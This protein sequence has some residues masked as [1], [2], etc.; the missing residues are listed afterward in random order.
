MKSKRHTF[1]KLKLA[2]KIYPKIL[3]Y[4]FLQKPTPVS[5]VL[6]ITNQCNLKCDYCFANP[7]KRIGKELSTEQLLNYIDQ[8]IGLG[9]E[10]IELQGGE[11]TLRSDLGRL[12]A[13]IVDRRVECSIVTNGFQV[14]RYLKQL[15]KCYFV[16]VSIDGLPET[17]NFHRGERAYE[18]AVGALEMM[19]DAGI[20]VRMHGVITFTTTKSDIDHLINLAEKY[21]TD[22][23]FVYALDTGIVKTGCGP[24]TN[25]P[26]QI[27]II[28]NYLLE[29]KDRGAP[30][31]SKAGAIRQALN[32]PF[33]SQDIL[34]EKEMTKRQGE[35]LKNLRIPRCLWGDLACFFNPDGKLYLC[36]RGFDRDG[37][38]VRIGSRPIRQVFGELSKIKP[39]YMC[40]QMGDLSHSFDLGCDN[41]RTW[42]MF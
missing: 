23:N 4:R 24:G 33:G 1:A 28:G 14:D 5:V 18:T 2:A 8:F 6:G 31:T 39:C 41:I 16:C 26:Q 30:I 3:K 13:Y 9:T 37:F 27:K 36:P 35:I 34:I 10:L 17:T 40:G 7:Q 38:F 12:I 21:K 11:P 22:I 15:K 25:F 42:F 29:L 32:W 19:V 20:S